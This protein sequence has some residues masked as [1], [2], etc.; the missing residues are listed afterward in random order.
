MQ[1]KYARLGCRPTNAGRIAEHT[2]TMTYRAIKLI[3]LSLLCGLAGVAQ[4]NAPLVPLDD[5]TPQAEHRRATRLITHVIANYH[6]RNVALDDDLSRVVLER[7][8]EALDPTR[9]YFL[10][11]DIDDF[12]QHATRVD[13]YL[14]SS[15]LNPLFEMFV[16][17]RERLRERTDFAVSALDE[18]FDFTANDSIDFD[19]ENAPW[20]VTQTDIDSLW[21]KRVKNDVLSLRLAGKKNDEIKETLKKRYTG[22]FRRTAQLNSEDVFQTLVNAYTTAIDPHTSYFSPRTSEN[23]KIRMSLSLEGIGAVLQSE[24]E[25]TLV[26]E[27]VPGGPAAQSGKLHADDRIVG[28]GQN[29][30]GPLVDVVGWRL[31]DVVDLIR[32]PKNS[33]VRLQILPKGTGLDGPTSLISITRNTIQLDDQA[34]KGSVIEEPSASGTMPIGV[35][36]V[37]TFYMDF[38]ARS[39]G[40]E[41]YRST[42]RD[43][44][45]IIT[46]LKR[47]KVAGLVIDL[48]GNGG[49]SLSE[50][51]ELTG[52][53]IDQGPVVQ[54]RDSQG[55][56]QIERDV[57]A[58]VAYDGPLVVLIDRNSASA[59]EIFAGAIQD[60]HRGVLVGEPSFG[61]GTVQN[62]VDLNRF[63]QSMEGKLGQLKATIA[64]FFRVSGSS[65]QFRGVTPEIVLPTVVSLD[66]QGERSLDNALPWAAIE[67][68]SYTP[69]TLSKNT[70]AT[71][72]REHDERILH[73]D[74]FKALVDMETAI[75]EAREKKQLSLNEAERR[76]EHDT[77]RAEQRAR[78][79]R[80]RV[81]RGLKPVSDDSDPE[82]DAEGEVVEAPKM[83]EAEERALDI[84]LNEAGHILSDWVDA[85]STDKRLVANE[86]VVKPAPG[87]PAA[88]GG[89]AG[90]QLH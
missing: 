1:D 43:V 54:V 49:G 29:D 70:L 52:L 23:F 12:Q 2:H 90:E 25:M 30:K 16:R 87:Q 44:R 78:E 72:T 84:V 41:N 47:Q 60:Y 71:V 69:L 62:L 6:Y 7:Y 27:V 40:D 11:S 5:L 45:K 17:F 46:D 22:L 76:K 57:D 61:K 86:T 64:Q 38:E 42:T 55:R 88:T 21:R 9:S 35:I 14:R 20:P 65:T 83:D 19:R 26:R 8:I 58:G 36:N 82:L 66:D 50:A 85:S 28:I 18:P 79:N 39:A 77:A 56:V 73:D 81:A 67:A 13:D 24:N 31:D 15:S 10:Q 4:A 33:I 32:G 80:V 53:F 59:S 48:R 51:T 75:K 34:V 89:G 3:F 37:P 74:A 68:A 63:D